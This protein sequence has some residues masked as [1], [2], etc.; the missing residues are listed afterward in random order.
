MSMRREEG[1]RLEAAAATVAV[2]VAVAMAGGE[3]GILS[4]AYCS[5][6]LLLGMPVLAAGL[7][8]S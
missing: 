4:V 3:F 5:L 6:D 1:G 8:L 7:F 2:A